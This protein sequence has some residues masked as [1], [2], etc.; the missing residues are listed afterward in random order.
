MAEHTCQSIVVTCID[1]RFQ[2][3][4]DKWISLNFQKGDFD[5]VALAGGIFDLPAIIKQVEISHNLHHIKEVVLI[6]HEDCGAYGKEGNYKRHVQDLKSAKEKIQ[7]L[8]PDLKIS[9][10]YLHLDGVFEHVA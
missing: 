3:F 5:R 7:Q 2:A 10:Y 9:L 8:L 1:F 4:I 6:N